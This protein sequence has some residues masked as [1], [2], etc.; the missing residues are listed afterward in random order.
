MINP[1]EL[2]NKIPEEQQEKLKAQIKELQDRVTA[3]PT[4]SARFKI[5]SEQ[6]LMVSKLYEQIESRTEPGSGDK[7]PVEPSK[8][9][10][11]L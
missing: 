8:F 10:F 2:L 5:L 3:A 9:K 7:D 1:E 6:M 4:M 11:Q